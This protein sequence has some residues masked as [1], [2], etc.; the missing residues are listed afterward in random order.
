MEDAHSDG[1]HLQILGSGE[2]LEIT[3]S[4]PYIVDVG[5]FKPGDVE[6]ESLPVDIFLHT[7]DTIEDDGAVTS[8]DGVDRVVGS[9]GESAGCEEGGGCFSCC[10]CCISCSASG[11]HTS[12]GDVF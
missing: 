7:G 2:C 3:G 4:G 1:D 6:V 9:V 5:T 8:F 12:R 11:G 10:S